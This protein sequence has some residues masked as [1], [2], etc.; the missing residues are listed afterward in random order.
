MPVLSGGT[1]G[2]APGLTCHYEN[3]S[4]FSA[5]KSGAVET[6]PP[7]LPRGRLR[8]V[9]ACIGKAWTLV[10]WKKGEPGKKRCRCY[11]CNS[12]RHEGECRRRKGAQDFV[13]AKEAILSRDGWMYSVLTSDPRDT[14]QETYVLGG[15]RWNRL[16][17]SLTKRF[18]KFEYI[19]TWER[20]KKGKAHVN[21]VLRSP[22]ILAMGWRRF[23]RIYGKLAVRAGF[24]KII[25]VEHVK[26]SV[27]MAGYMVKLARELT[28]SDA[29]NQVPV[30]A[31]RHFRRIRASRGLLPK[32]FKN[33][34]ITG[35]LKQKPLE[36]VEAI[37]EREKALTSSDS[38]CTFSSERLGETHGEAEEQ[39][40]GQTKPEA[41]H[42]MPGLRDVGPPRGGP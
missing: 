20:T 24:G 11:R 27:A 35:E 2:R 10:T 40:Q 7:P 15:E 42:S 34:E 30:N 6:L 39:S 13:R 4:N 16:R 32:V 3:N 25:W 9:A 23:R 29:K 22:K 19:Q 12:W 21:V 31:P 37:L 28:G 26:D 36:V 14:E 1:G 33:P 41:I 5:E 8:Y 18:G 17:S 38:G